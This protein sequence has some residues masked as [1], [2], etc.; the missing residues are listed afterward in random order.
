MSELAGMLNFETESS[1]SRSEAAALG[2]DLKSLTLNS[3]GLVIGRP[4]GL[5]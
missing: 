2:N 4:V 1:G 5:C 3:G